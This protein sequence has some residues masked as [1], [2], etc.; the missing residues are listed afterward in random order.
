[1]TLKTSL[2]DGRGTGN[3]VGVSSAGELTLRGIGDN[4]SISRSL[5]TP[6]QAYNFFSPLSGQTFVITSII[7]SSNQNN[8]S[9][10]IFSAP[11]A[12]SIA[13]D[14]ELITIGI[15]NATTL[16]ITLP[17]GGFLPVGEG[18]FLNAITDKATLYMTIIG[19]YKPI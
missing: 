5:S 1:M 12:T 7:T 8:L 15:I 6:G 4:Q 3:L 9:L 19:F 2:K 16:A 14:T 17:F 10:T 18:E 13:T 11:S